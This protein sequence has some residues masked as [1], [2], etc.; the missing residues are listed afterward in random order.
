MLPHKPDFHRTFQILLASAVSGISH[1]LTNATYCQLLSSHLDL[2]MSL[3]TTAGY[4]PI[5]SINTLSYRKHS[6]RTRKWGGGCDT[7]CISYL[8]FWLTSIRKA[9]IIFTVLAEY[10]RDG[11]IL[12]FQLASKIQLHLLVFT[13][14]KEGG[15]TKPYFLFSHQK[16]SFFLYCKPYHVIFF[17]KH[18]SRITSMQI[19]Q[20]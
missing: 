1:A 20:P 3:L 15:F 4:M 19:F 8:N 11:C 13:P 2:L 10:L 5:L 6:E 12:V 17:S 7:I 18:C 16:C 9:L 14:A